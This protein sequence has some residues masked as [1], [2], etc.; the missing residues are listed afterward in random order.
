M[1]R[2]GLLLLNKGKWDGTD[3]LKD[4]SYFKAM[5]TSSQSINNSYGYLTWLNGKSSFMLPST[6]IVFNGFLCPDA[7]SDMYAALGKNGQIINVVPSQN[8]VFIR[9]GN[10]W[11]TSNVPNEFN[12]DIWKRLKLVICASL[13]SMTINYPITITYPNPTTRFIEV[14]LPNHNYS[15]QL[16]DLYGKI[17]MANPLEGPIDLQNLPVGIYL[18]KIYQ[19]NAL[20]FKYF[21]VQ[22][23][24]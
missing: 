5:T 15:Y 23:I 13:S 18:L 19:D 10:M 22:K 24:N 21:K 2:F 16:V 12:N 3:L 4:S 1:A 6:Q 9:M 20:E 11:T 7:P 14:N 17:L 8:L